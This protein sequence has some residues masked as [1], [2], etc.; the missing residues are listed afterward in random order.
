M[1]VMRDVSLQHLIVSSS[2]YNICELMRVRTKKPAS[3]SVDMLRG[4]CIELRVDVSNVTQREMQLWLVKPTEF[5]ELF[6]VMRLFT[7]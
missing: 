4:I 1:H 6:L 5:H 2:G 7:R 3:L